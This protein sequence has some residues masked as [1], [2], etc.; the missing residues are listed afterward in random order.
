M[1]RSRR[2]SL[3]HRLT[4][5][6]AN[7]LNGIMSPGINLNSDKVASNCKITVA[8]K[9]YIQKW[10]M[11]RALFSGIDVDSDEVAST[12]RSPRAASFEFN[13]AACELT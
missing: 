11:P 5:C 10:N 7:L 12:A 4:S 3:D 6:L 8:S 13:R 9:A 2:T 1:T